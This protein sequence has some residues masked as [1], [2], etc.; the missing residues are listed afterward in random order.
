MPNLNKVF[1]MGRLTRDPEL[2]YTTSGMAIARLGLAVNRSWRSQDS[3]ELKE[4]T[5][6]IDVDAFGKQAETL[7]QYLK[8]GRPIYVE[9]RLKLDSWEDKQSGQK[10]TRL[11]VVLESFQFIDGGGR[12]SGGDDYGDSHDSGPSGR[13]DS[14]GGYSSSPPPQSSSSS[15]S[16][17]DDDDDDVPF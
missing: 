4:E 16:S 8:K 11:G 10:R 1:L 15:S 13:G 14:G 12:D 3:R 6:F 7:G 5:T 9:G 17:M 2:R